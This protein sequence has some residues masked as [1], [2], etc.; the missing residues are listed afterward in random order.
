M[1]R[2]ASSIHKQIQFS[3]LHQ[4]NV[5]L[6]LQSFDLSHPF[7]GCPQIKC[8]AS[9]DFKNPSNSH[10]HNGLQDFVNKIE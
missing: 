1:N 4:Q 6:D 9:M 3:R 10:K 7:S 2:L 5:F 8:S